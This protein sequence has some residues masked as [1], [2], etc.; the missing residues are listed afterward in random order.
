MQAVV[1]GRD[2]LAVLPSGAGKTAVYQVAGQLLDGPV[3]VVS[4][5]IALQRDQVE[6]LAEIEDRAGRA[7]QLNSTLSAGD[8]REVLEALAGRNGPLRLP[9]PR[10]ADQ[11]GGGRRRPRRAVRRCS[12][13]TRR[14]ASPP[15]ATTS[16]P[17]TCA[18]AAS[19][20]SSATRPCSPSPPPRP[21]RSA[22]RSSSG[23]RCATRRSSSPASTGRRSGW[24]STTTPTPTAR[25]RACST[26]S[27]PRSAR[28]AGPGIVYSATRKGTEEIAAQL[29]D[30]GLR[31]RHYHAG[32]NKA[33]RED[34]QR[35]WMDDE[36][37]VVVATTAFGMGIDKPGTRFVVHAEPA[38]SVDSYYQE[39]GRAGRDGQPAL[40]VLV[41]RQEDLGIRRFFAAG[42]PG[43]GGAPAGRR[44]GRRGGRGRD[45]GRR[46]RQGPAR[47]DR[48]RRDAADPRPEPAGGGVGRRPG[49]RRRRPPGRERAVPR[50]GRRGGPRAGRAPREGRPEPRGD[51]ARLRRDDPLPPPVPARLLRRAAG[52]PLRQLRHLLRRQ[53]R[54]GRGRRP[55]TCRSPPRRRSSTASGARAWSCGWRRTASSSCS[56]RSATRRLGIAAVMENE[57]L[58][59]RSFT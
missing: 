5:L 19:S 22:P 56:T 15:G 39:I 31:A 46:R 13:S 53:R 44:P 11:A 26:G 47:G 37:D 57:L 48:P 27:W 40:A 10:A 8:Q 58:R 3:V 43:G 7:V 36:L 52:R 14:T 30:R 20:S 2:T 35:A 25:S 28:G 16:G 9:R 54:T 12:S 18:S 41:Y 45:R 23:W 21:R 29:A 33:D 55:T 34:T 24:R 6:R 1:A 32:L 38:D 50:R 59:P 42:T 17:T 4:P 51:D 49:R